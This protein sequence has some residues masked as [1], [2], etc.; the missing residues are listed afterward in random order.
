MVISNRAKVICHCNSKIK[1][2]NV[3]EKEYKA[4]SFEDTWVILGIQKNA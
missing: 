2:L 4:I 3:G 1:N